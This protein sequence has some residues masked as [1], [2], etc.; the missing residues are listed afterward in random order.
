V[1]DKKETC[2]GLFPMTTD[3]LQEGSKMNYGE[4]LAYWYSN[5]FFQWS[6]LSK[7]WTKIES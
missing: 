6:S 3:C 7:F 1:K 2:P 4:E 5:F